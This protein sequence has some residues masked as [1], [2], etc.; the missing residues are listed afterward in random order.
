MNDKCHH[1]QAGAQVHRCELVT[2]ELTA[3]FLLCAVSFRGLSKQQRSFETK[4][5]QPRYTNECHVQS[6]NL[7]L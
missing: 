6:S 5:V 1:R 3:G 7:F 2:T 4:Y